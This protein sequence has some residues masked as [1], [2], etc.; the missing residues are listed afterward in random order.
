MLI[1]LSFSLTL[2]YAFFMQ[3]KEII[4]ICFDVRNNILLVSKYIN[5]WAWSKISA[6]FCPWSK[7]TETEKANKLDKAN[8]AIVANKTHELDDL[9]VPDESIDDFDELL[10][11]DKA[12]D[13]FNELVVTK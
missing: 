6:D 10:M 3:D 2:Y 4:G 1:L 12:V 13:E 5:H 11:A 8:E 9:A 7:A